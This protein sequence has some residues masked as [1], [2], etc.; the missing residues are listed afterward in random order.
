MEPQETTPSEE[1]E[2]RKVMDRWIAAVRQKDLESLLALYSNDFVGFDIVPPLVSNKI[3]YE[4]SWKQFFDMA[5]GPI[6]CE[7]S[8]VKTVIVGGNAF[9]HLLNHMQYKDKE[10]NNNDTWLR[11]T[12]L[13][14]NQR[15]KW[16]CTHEHVSVPIDMQTKQGVF[17]LKP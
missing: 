12:V 3:D 2:V 1:S 16:L 13:M 8:Q 9:I 14:R 10:G 11:A 7:V 15:G 6:Q 5:D 17:D 4:K